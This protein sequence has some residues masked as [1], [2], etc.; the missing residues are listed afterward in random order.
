MNQKE[1]HP[2]WPAAV[3]LPRRSS[4]SHAPTFL[5]L[6]RAA[7]AMAI[8]ST[9]PLLN[10][11]CANKSRMNAPQLL[12]RAAAAMAGRSA[13]SRRSSPSCASAHGTSMHTHSG[14]VV[15]ALRVDDSRTRRDNVV[16]KT[17]EHEPASS[18]HEATTAPS[19]GFS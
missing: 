18:F 10:F 4:P 9:V 7:A 8:R 11:P 16:Y 19:L 3:L 1:R 15:K 6:W 13:A 2:L 12:W 17:W 5:E 14:S